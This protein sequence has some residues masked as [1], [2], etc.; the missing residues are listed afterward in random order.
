MNCRFLF[1]LL[2]ALFSLHMAAA[3]TIVEGKVTS[4]DGAPL[5]GVA[6]VIDGTLTGTVS[7]DDGNWSL[8]ASQ[9]DVL[10]FSCLGYGTRHC[11]VQGSGM[12]PLPRQ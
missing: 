11:I 3:Q 1:V 2:S 4:P 9:G 7:D 6:V 8:T 12:P 5:P 10:V